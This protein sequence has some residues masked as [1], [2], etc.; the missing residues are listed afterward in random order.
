MKHSTRFLTIFLFLIIGIQAKSQSKSEQIIIEKFSKYYNTS[1]SDSIFALF[2]DNMQQAMPL[3]KTNE[4][5]TGL[6]QGLGMIMS[7]EFTKHA[8]Q[9][10]VFKT[11]FEKGI[12]NINLAVDENDEICGLFIKPYIDTSI[13]IIERNKTALIL[14]FYGE[15]FTFW[16]GET[17]EQNYHVAIEAQKGAFDL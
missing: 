7:S 14:P 4:F 1:L 17:V 6:Q 3:N 2:D 8:N 5:V 9:V 12:F 16:G 13:P 15:W 11:S 10:A